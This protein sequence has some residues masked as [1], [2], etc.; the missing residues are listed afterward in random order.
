MCVNRLKDMQLALIICRLYDNTFEQTHNEV[1]KK[2]VLAS[3]S[4]EIYKG[5]E[6]FLF[7]LLK[8]YLSL[9]LVRES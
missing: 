3:D 7:H 9:N 6:C 2:F 8:T 1:L 5:E 4:D